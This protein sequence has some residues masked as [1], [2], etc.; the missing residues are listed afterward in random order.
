MHDHHTPSSPCCEEAIQFHRLPPLLVERPQ[1]LLWKYEERGGRLTKVP[2]QPNDT[3][4]STTNPATWSSL[5]SVQ[6]ARW[7][8]I[9]RWDGPHYDG[10]G[11][12]FSQDDPFVGIDLDHCRGE[13]W[14]A[15][16]LDRFPTYIEITPSLTGYHLIGIGSLP[17]G[18]GRRHESIEIYDRGRYFTMTGMTAAGST[19]NPMNIQPQLD[20]LLQ[21]F[22]PLVTVQQRPDW[23]PSMAMEQLLRRMFL[24][25]NG[26]KVSAL[27]Q[28]DD[29]G[30]E[31]SSEADLALIQCAA[32]YT[33]N[34]SDLDAIFRGSARMREKWDERH[35]SQT[36][37]EMTI[38][39]AIAN[40]GTFYGGRDIEPER[41]GDR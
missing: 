35:G 2:Y 31:S 36:Y 37:G 20:S 1:W 3:L 12:V 19:S 34:P 26:S 41:R 4:A 38:A 32:L 18:K 27:Y 13:A 17:E 28:G 11:F 24:A 8:C 14:A 30:Y 33:Q 16:F 7:S 10:V 21:S 39:R 40:Q 5:A 25:K 29:S 22:A 15:E 6:E 23:V 9:G